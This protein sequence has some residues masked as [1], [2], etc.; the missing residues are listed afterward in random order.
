MGGMGGCSSARLQRMGRTGQ[1]RN[2]DNSRS[3]GPEFRSESQG[4]LSAE[5]D[6][7]RK[8]CQ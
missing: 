7:H 3:K 4:E 8:L 6:V 2:Q 5:L 1:G